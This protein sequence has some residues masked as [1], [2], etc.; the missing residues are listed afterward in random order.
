[1]TKMRSSRRLLKA[2]ESKVQRSD[3]EKAMKVL[4]S[5]KNQ[6]EKA[7]HVRAV[8][9]SNTVVVKL[10]VGNSELKGISSAGHRVVVSSLS[11]VDQSV[12]DTER[13]I[14]TIQR[15]PSEK[16]KEFYE[17]LASQN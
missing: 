13:A 6:P 4:K 5:F 8:V 9:S 10:Q 14:R 7:K 16:V 3:L 12:K 1:M 2:A 15:A 11:V 17:R